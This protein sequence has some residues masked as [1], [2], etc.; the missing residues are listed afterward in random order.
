MTIVRRQSESVLRKALSDTPVVFINGARQTGKST[1]VRTV[2]QALPNFTYKSLDDLNTCASAKNDPIGFIRDLNGIVAIDEV[3]KATDLLP[4]I[5][6]SVD[7][8]RRP[9]RFILTGSANILLLPQVSESLA[10]RME[11][12]TINPLAMSEI[13]GSSNDFIGKLFSESDNPFAQT[14]DNPLPFEHDL[15]FSGGY[16]EVVLS[17]C[18]VERRYVW[19]SSYLTSILQRDIRDIANISDLTEFP[20]L[21]ALIA[22]RSGSILNVADLS[23]ALS[24]PMTTLKRYI[25]YLE[26]AFLV[27][28][29]AAW[30]GSTAKQ[31]IK[32]PKLYVCDTGLMAYLCG[33]EKERYLSDGLL[34]GQMFESFVGLELLKQITWAKQYGLK[35]YHYR[36]S[37]GDGVD[38][39]IQTPSGD[40]VGIEVKSSATT[41]AEDFAALRRLAS[42]TGKKFIRGVVV[43]SGTQTLSFGERLLAVPVSQLW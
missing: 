34:R 21:L 5:K 11:I 23:R 43:Y 29:V 17:R 14:N 41:G 4:T 42:I 22:T 40:F 9:G 15:I 3:Q 8:D 18:D 32:S 36:T 30:H 6:L 2:G 31:I 7:N 28:R 19:F 16:P 27:C 24:I 37:A 35:L 33:A 26:T 38:F 39:I 25:S 20:R 13:Y 1:L 12:I 10:G